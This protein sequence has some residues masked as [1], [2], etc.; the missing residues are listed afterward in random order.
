MIHE[1]MK[2]KSKFDPVL[3]QLV[4]FV[5]DNQINISDQ[6]YSTESKKKWDWTAEK[7]C[8]NSKVDLDYVTFT[9]MNDEFMAPA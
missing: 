9:L 8:N 1:F 2:Q 6:V 5:E 7:N 4:R 3:A